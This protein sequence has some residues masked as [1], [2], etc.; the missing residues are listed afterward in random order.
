MVYGGL[1][2]LLF[3][4]QLVINKISLYFLIYRRTLVVAHTCESNT[5]NSTNK[6]NKNGL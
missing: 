5:T 1:E 6:I 2:F 3:D 4:Y